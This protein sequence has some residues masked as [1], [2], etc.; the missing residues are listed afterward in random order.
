MLSGVLHS[1]RAIHVN[2]VIMRTFVKLRSLVISE[3]EFTQK[4]RALEQKHDHK[5]KVVFNAIRELMSNRPVP[6]P[7]RPLE[8]QPV[9]AGSKAASGKTSLG[10]NLNPSCWQACPRPA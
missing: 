6:R 7:R 10:L 4:L 3:G 9:V 2:T 5:F 8:M 1:E